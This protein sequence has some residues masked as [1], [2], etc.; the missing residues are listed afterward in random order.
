MSRVK[1][2]ALNAEQI[3]RF[4]SK[5]DR[6]G[7]NGCWVW[8]G[9]CNKKGYGHFSG[10]RTM[11]LA[12]RVS[13]YLTTGSQPGRL[14]VQHTCP[15]GRDNPSC[16]NPDHLM[17]GTSQGN[18]DRRNSLG[19]QASGER[20]GTA[21]LTPDKVMLILEANGKSTRRLAKVH[22]VSHTAIGDVLRGE[23][24]KNVER[25]GHETDLTLECG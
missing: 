11:Y 3:A 7:P 18:M 20:S 15:D 2:I 25:P 6:N 12:H 16:V 23:T 1:D 24:W 8:T 21:K 10:T 17:P 4:W 5:V 13:Y 19:R 22:G 9:F 14:Q